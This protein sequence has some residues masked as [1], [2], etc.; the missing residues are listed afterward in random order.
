MFSFLRQLTTWHC[1]HLLPSAGPCSN[2]SISSGSRA[3]SSKPAA[4]AE[5]WDRRTYR[6]TLDSF[7]DPAPHTVGSV[8]INT[9]EI[10][11]LRRYKQ[12]PPSYSITS[13]TLSSLSYAVLLRSQVRSDVIT[14]QKLNSHSPAS[15]AG[16]KCCSIHRVP[17][18]RDTNSRFFFTFRFSSKFAAN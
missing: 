16:C 8:S 6:R 4:A 2:W 17:K 14:Q 1:S 5:W 18:K 9:A 3:H 15:N 7:I 11:T 12:I 13:L 10:S